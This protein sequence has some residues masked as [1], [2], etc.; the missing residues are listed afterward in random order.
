MRRKAR[1][2]LNLLLS[3]L[4]LLLP[5]CPALA[6]QPV[7]QPERVN[8]NTGSEAELMRLPF[9]GLTMARRII[10][11]RRKHGFFKRPQDVVVVKGMSA[12]RYR[13]IA[14]L[15]RTE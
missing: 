4:L 12:R 8:L 9:V 3:G 15:I 1:P 7:R 11:Y 6:V 5:L 13:Q 14:H 2:H 10:E